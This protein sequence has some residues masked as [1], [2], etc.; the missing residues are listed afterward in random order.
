MTAA[1][2]D[3]GSAAM[4]TVRPQGLLA[5]RI[6]I[7]A[8]Y[9]VLSTVTVMI[10]YGGGALT[11]LA[12]RAPAGFA[13]GYGAVSAMK[14]L[15]FGGFLVIV[16][17]AGRSVVAVQWVLVGTATWF[18][19]DLISP[20]DPAQGFWA[21]VVQYVML[22]VLYVGPWLALAPERRDLFRLRAHP[23]RVAVGTALAALP[24]LLLWGRHQADLVVSPGD[25]GFDAVAVPLI[26]ASVSL[27][28]ALRPARRRW[29]LVMIAAFSAY[30]GAVALLTPH[31]DVGSP[32][33]WGGL[34]LVLFAGLFAWRASMPLRPEADR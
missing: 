6:A 3:R 17:T 23:D 15:S 29:L 33:W 32:G 7:C 8:V 11:M 31:S 13:F 20:Q 27:F 9:L 12:G 5:R 14:L 19:T 25:S 30:L 18:V 28:A 21:L 2:T 4:T 16:A 24:L 1:E 26:W 22:V 34:G 10:A